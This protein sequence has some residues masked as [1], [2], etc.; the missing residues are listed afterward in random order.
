MTTTPKILN[1]VF[2][3]SDT[4][5]GHRSAAVAIEAALQEAT[6][7]NNCLLTSTI[8]DILEI[9]QLPVICKA[10]RLYDTLST[11]GL[12][13]YNTIFQLSNGAWQADVVTS[14]MM[15]WAHKHIA[16]EI[17]AARP[18]VIICT[19]SLVQRAISYVRRRYLLPCQIITVVTDLVSLHH[20]WACNDVECCILTT[21][22]AYDLTQRRGFPADRMI[23]TG[24]PVHPKFVRYTRTQQH[25]RRDLNIDEDTFTILVT[26]GGV[27]AGRMSDL[28]LNLEQVFPH[29]QLLV[30]TG[31]NHNRYNEIQS[32]KR[33]RFTHVYGFVQNMEELMAASD[34]VVTK[35]G[36]GTLMEAL[37]MRRPVI[38]T[39][40]IGMQE[41]GNIDFVQNHQLGFFCPTFDHIFAAINTLIDRTVYEKTV[42]RLRDAVPRDGAA[43]IA[44]IVLRVVTT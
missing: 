7:Q 40:A 20:S 10:P 34:I 24:F 27:G 29:M 8:L 16:R 35:A 32:S 28:V 9:S 23:R 18:H 22:E 33:S 25:A 13:F 44:D 1:V 31:K 36:P 41:H 19:H 38:I 26:G 11:K 39:E 30:V 15:P 4:G 5:S 42:T 43:Q 3:L 2:A 12:K 6:S 21:D 37:V 14:L 17:Q